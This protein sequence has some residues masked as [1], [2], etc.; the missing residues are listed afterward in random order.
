METGPFRSLRQRFINSLAHDKRCYQERYLAGR[1]FQYMPICKK[2]NKRFPNYKVIKNKVRHLGKRKYCLKCSRFNKHNTRDLTKKIISKK[3]IKCEFCSKPY[4]Y[5]KN[6]KGGGTL[7]TRTCNSC[8]VNRRRFLIKEK[9]IEYK[10]GKCQFCGYNKCSASLTF[11][12]LDPKKKDFII[13]GNH[14]LSFKRIK[15]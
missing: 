2:C 6:K 5:R 7:N 9:C 8:R 12:H 13:G 15:R 14:C 4:L 11:H 10:G 1:P 3:L